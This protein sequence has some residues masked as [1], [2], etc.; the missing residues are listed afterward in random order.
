[1]RRLAALPPRLFRLPLL[2]PVLLPVLL[3]LLLQLLLLFTFLPGTSLAQNLNQLPPCPRPDYSKAQDV[4][5]SGRTWHWNDC[6][7]R[8]VFDLRDDLR[9][10]I[11]EG[12]WRHGK[13]TG[14]GSYTSPSGTR[15]VGEFRDFLRQGRGQL[16][17]AEGDRY[18]GEF[19]NDHFHGQGTYRFSNGDLYV[20]EFADGEFH[21]QG[22]FTSASGSRY[23]GEYR[24]DQRSGVGTYIG[25]EGDKYVGEYKDGLRNGQGSYV[26][27]SG[28]KYF[29]EFRDG[30][31]H[32]HGTLIM[33]DGSRFEGLW[34]RG[35][36]LRETSDD[37][38]TLAAQRELEREREQLAQER[39]QLEDERRDLEIARGSDDPTPAPD[40]DSDESYVSG[41][42]FLITQDGYIVT[43]HHVVEGT[44][45]LTV[46]T[47]TGKTYPATIVR[48]DAKHDLALLKIDAAGLAHLPVADSSTVKKGTSVLAGGFPQIVVQGIEP[49]ITDGIISSL[50]G[51]MNDVTAFQI[52]NPI[53]P[54]NSGGPL[55]TLE[56]NVVGIVTAQ[57]SEKTM[58]RE[59]DSIPQNVNFAVK[60]NYLLEMLKG[61]RSVR[62]APP[63]PKRKFRST[64]DAVG[65]VEPALVLIIG[66]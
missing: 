13:L 22:T 48:V 52:S 66:Q 21:G 45:Q 12:E 2:L 41:S 15:Y 58:Q 30:E 53:Q 49:K 39:R 3:P 42:G 7:G 62:L 43:N 44:T 5:W 54:G 33:N 32:G 16:T 55:F 61:I 11:I 65:A 63:N 46:R 40:E 26:Y 14:R 59:F 28:E 27:A 6:W 64:E 35:K 9:G 18:D 31:F 38:R 36:L 24:H 56:G 37:A 50:T 34:E 60:S 8:Y 25:P 19:L 4:G 17:Y 57:L 47:T 1:M 23:V 29:G 10:T 20:G 51:I